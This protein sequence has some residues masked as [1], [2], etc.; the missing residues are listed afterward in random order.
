MQNRWFQNHIISVN[1]YIVDDNIHIT[2][3]IIESA[4]FINVAASTG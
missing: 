2:S 4:K 3:H 1:K